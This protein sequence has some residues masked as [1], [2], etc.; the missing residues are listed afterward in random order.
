MEFHWRDHADGG[1]SV[2]CP[3]CDAEAKQERM[4][5]RASMDANRP[6]ALS[7]TPPW[8]TAILD[9]GKTVENRTRLP[10]PKYRGPLYLHASNLRPR[11]EFH[12]AVQAILRALET[13]P[14]DARL[15]GIAKRHLL[16][17]SARLA[18]GREWSNWEPDVRIV[19]GAI[20]GVA[21]VVGIVTRI[22]ERSGWMV[23]EGDEQS[24]HRDL[25]PTERRWWF[26]GPAYL[27]ANVR[28]LCTPVPCRGRQGLWRPSPE[29]HAAVQ[30]ELEASR[31]G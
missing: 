25:T 1:C 6:R 8:P 21:D 16:A 4:D 29:V 30:A 9:L 12:E 22:G 10:S 11:V 3:A 5:A 13:T 23:R 2:G 20:V 27:L 26:G 19:Q 15:R 7:L 24:R 14:D 17:G 28:R 18:A 31:H